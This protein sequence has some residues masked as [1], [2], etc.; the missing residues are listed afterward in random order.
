MKIAII[1][2]G[3]GGL[4]C[5]LECERLGIIPD[6]FERDESVGWPYVCIVHWLHVIHNS[7]GDLHNYL[8]DRFGLDLKPINRCT[9]L[10]MRSQ[11]KETKIKG[12]IGYIM[13]RGKHVDS[14]ENQL[15][16]TLK[17]TPV[18]FNRPADY[19][20]LSKKYD[21]VVVATGK[22]TVAKELGVWK[23]ID[24]VHLRG[25]LA[26]GA[27]NPTS[28]T[29]YFNMK[30]VGQGLARLGPINSTQAIVGMCHIGDDELEIDRHYKDFLEIEDLEDLEFGYKF[31]IPMWT[32]GRVNK[33]Q[34]DNVLLVGRSAGLTERFLG[35][36]AIEALMSGTYAA[37]AMIKG[38]DYSTLVKPLQDHV[39]NISSFRKP[40][41]GLDNDGLDRLISAIDTPVI[42][43]LICNSGLNFVDFFGPIQRQI[44][45][46]TNILSGKEIE[47]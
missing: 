40:F 28:T 7:K 37:R 39:E 45:K 33:F 21:F 29:I 42:K 43:Q 32:D 47:T 31:S 4:A 3:L 27:F 44:N 13:R 8:R 11:N 19:K 14:V 30:H 23:S 6:V 9:E 46:V 18:H 36:G 2:A 25:G 12:D 41:E 10:I 1:G 24:M 20:E 22:E 26:Y 5:A 38:L 16:R 17:R 34:V 15:Y 35:M